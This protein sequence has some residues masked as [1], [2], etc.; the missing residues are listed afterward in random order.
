MVAI[1]M[2]AAK[3][4]ALGLPKIKVLWYKAYNVII[5]VHDV[6]NRISS[7]DSNCVVD[8][9]MWSTFG[10]SRIYIREAITTSIL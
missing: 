9:V 2:M 8:V 7:L 10:N 4:A 3:M 6:I 5:Y 1:L